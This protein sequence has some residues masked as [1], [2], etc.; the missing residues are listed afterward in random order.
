M[1][2]VLI[3]DDEVKIVQLIQCLV[4][5]EDFDMEVV[6]TANDGLTAFSLISELEPDIVITDIRM[7]NVSGVEL[8]QCTQ[9]Q[10]LHPYFI[11]V[12][13]YSDFE[14]A[15]QAIKLG[16]E[17]YLLK[18]LK[19]KEL[20]SVLTKIQEKAGLAEKEL[21]H[22]I[23]LNDALITSHAKLKNALLTDLLIK[24]KTSVSR[25]SAEELNREY[26][27]SFPGSSY[28]CVIWHLFS[29][30]EREQIAS[31][32]EYQFLLPKLEKELLQRI[33]G[34]CRET[35]SIALEHEILFLL[36]YDEVCQMDLEDQL[37]RLKIQFLNYRSIYPDMQMCLCMGSVAADFSGFVQS[38]QDARTA[39]QMRF[40][41]NGTFFLKYQPTSSSVLSVND[42]LTAPLKAKL[43]KEIELLN[44]AGFS[45]VLDEVKI[46]L[47]KNKNQGTVLYQCYQLLADLFLLNMAP[48][49]EQNQL[50]PLRHQMEDVLQIY[51]AFED[52]FSCFQDLCLN[53]IARQRDAKKE[54][55]HLPIRQARQYLQEHFAEPI[56]L[57][58]VSRS[59]GFNPAYFSTLF[60]K[61][62]GQNFSDYL[63]KI[64]ITQAQNMLTHTNMGIADIAVACG[65]SD[66]KYFSKL[67]KR[68]TSI[69]P[70]EFRKLYG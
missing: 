14:Y 31:Q 58:S 51:S 45:A 12:S 40:D 33:S 36:N 2:T 18:P 61:E 27:V 37:S 15:Q 35:L 68:N 4:R 24:E 53:C 60:K 65:Y 13:G 41:K 46:L 11:I 6:A 21:A 59:V 5:W 69:T 42:I 17:D 50:T 62:T 23:A 32:E 1:L 9:N 57:E 55:E 7:P 43:T 54:A 48:H 3:A 64:R 25:M 34:L 38:Y 16:V 39:L 22:R 52:A 70:S 30:H 67:F 66:V 49:M 29:E 56:S 63:I 28:V 10:G 26:G 19:K 8:V 44:H 47:L 20:E